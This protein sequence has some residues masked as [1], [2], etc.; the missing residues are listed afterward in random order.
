MH[1]QSPQLPLHRDLQILQRDPAV[2]GVRILLP[3]CLGEKRMPRISRKSS[4]SMEV[5]DRAGCVPGVSRWH[6]RAESGL[7]GLCQP[8]MAQGQPQG[9]NE[10][11]RLPA[12]KPCPRPEPL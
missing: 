12:A 3:T 10:G 5:W 2:R 8:G 9:T 6:P 11:T 4:Q 1:G 7:P